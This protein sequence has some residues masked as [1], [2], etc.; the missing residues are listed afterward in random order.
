[1]GFLRICFIAFLLCMHSA[2]FADS[3]SFVPQVEADPTA[4]IDRLLEES[5]MRGLIAGGVVLIGERQGVLFERSYGKSSAEPDASPM[6]R[7]TIFD[8]AS[9]TKVVATA[10]AVLKLAE[11]RRLS[12]VDPVSKWFPEFAGKGKEDLLVMNLL[13]HTSGLDDFYLPAGSAL[14][15]AINGAANQKN[16][17]DI[18]S[19]FKYADI[20]FILLSELVKR[21][22]GA[23]LDVYTATNFFTP[24][25]MMDT[26]FNPDKGRAVRCSSTV[27]EGKSFFRGIPQDPSAR[28]L[29]GVSGH[30][31]LF[32]TARD[33]AKFCQMLLAEGKW[34]GIKVI[35]ERAVRQMTAPYFSR[36]GQ[37]VR[38]LGWD[39]ASP[40]S[41]PRGNG[42][43][44]T[45][46]GHT[47]YSGS[48]LWIDPTTDTFV[49]L[50]T[51]RLEFRK[52]KEFGQLRSDLS[53]LA[54]ELFSRRHTAGK[55]V[56]ATLQP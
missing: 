18:G 9:L 56:Q 44:E 28:Q 25:G 2:A 15:T 35:S 52:T 50:L 24:I 46:F 41:S 14:E 4:K 53:S 36:G 45:S 8:I 5:I 42:F 40:Y 17:G 21:V 48:S 19:R 10:P 31:G 37:V 39:I 13:T 12:L 30:A 55:L 3:S 32:S 34:N 20:N 7:D 26:G 6:D 51:A 43:S 29:G 11:D 49:I 38:G 16:R 47:G 22:S 54:A 1:M 33:L 27:G 23:S